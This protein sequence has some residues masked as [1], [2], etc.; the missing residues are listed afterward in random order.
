MNFS[1]DYFYE[2]FFKSMFS[3]Y[4]YVIY[5]IAIPGN[6]KYLQRQENIELQLKWKFLGARRKNSVLRER[7]SRSYVP[8]T[9][10]MGKC[11]LYRNALRASRT[12]D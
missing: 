2:S 12:N 1:N 7:S 9:K 4:C 11:T 5:M 3:F 10:K 6:N 8:I